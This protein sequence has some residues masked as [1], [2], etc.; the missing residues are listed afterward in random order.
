[1]PASEPNPRRDATLGLIQ[2][3]SSSP[4][5]AALLRGLSAPAQGRSAFAVTRSSAAAQRWGRAEA[6]PSCARFATRWSARRARG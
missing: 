3:T 6:R 1:L 5:R 4:R 2:H